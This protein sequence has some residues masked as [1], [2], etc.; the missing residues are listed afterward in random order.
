M[1]QFLHDHHSTVFRQPLRLGDLEHRQFKAV[2]PH[3]RYG[4]LQVTLTQHGGE[5]S[6]A[7]LTPRRRVQGHLR[8]GRGGV[9]RVQIPRG[10]RS[11]HK[12]V[13]NGDLFRFF[14][15]HGGD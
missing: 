3:R 6:T 2:V 9:N 7:A 13:I 8:R 15:V 11:R 14:T 12:H 1:P 4:D 10:Q 5:V